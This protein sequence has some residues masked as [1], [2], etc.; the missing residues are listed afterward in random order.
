[1]ERTTLNQETLHKLLEIS[2]N[3]AE[4]RFLDPLLEYAIDVALEL[5]GAEYGYLVIRREGG[6]IDVRVRK[7]KFGNQLEIPSE[8]LSKTILEKVFETRAPVLTADAIVDPNF[9]VSQSVK[10]LRLRSVMCVPLLSHENILGAIYIENRSEKGVFKKSDLLP[11]QYL[12][13][14]AAVSIENALINEELEARVSQRTAELNQVVT[15]L[16]AEVQAKKRVEAELRKLSRAVEQSPNSIIITDT[17]GRIEY[18]NP[19]FTRLTGYESEEVLGK[20]PRIQKSGH[21]PE[22]VYSKLWNTITSGAIW[23]GEFVNQKKNGDLYWELAVIAPIRDEGGETTHYV[24]IKEDI[25]KRKHAEAEL[26]RYAST[27]SLTGIYNRR[28]LF[29][30]AER[31]F[32]QAKRYRRDLSVL[33]V[34][35]DHF[36]Q[37]NDQFGHAVGDKVLQVIAFYLIKH[38]RATD[39][40]GRYG[41]E[42]FLIIMPETGTQQAR[43]VADRLLE[44]FH[45]NP[46]QTKSGRISVTISI[47]ITTL[48]Q[49]SISTFY[50]MIDQADQALYHAKRNGRNRIAVYIPNELRNSV[51]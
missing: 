12:A 21:T 40:L 38:M 48:S 22:E 43:L 26:Q 47:G 33:M 6:A 28:Y 3:M 25:T 7:D 1:M 11:L 46:I 36:K 5:F 51:P 18:V 10:S 20:N 14:Q 50:R 35:I 31:A 19:A 32:G 39:I 42:E 2:R 30:L 4:N 49:N 24:A 37:V 9:Q 27:D 8:H 13:A 44:H 34:D 16:E 45:A 15:R 23:R 17:E 29:Q 41:G